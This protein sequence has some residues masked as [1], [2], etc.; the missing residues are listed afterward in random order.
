MNLVN[1]YW[2]SSC[3]GLLKDKIVSTHNKLPPDIVSQQ[4]SSSR[5]EHKIALVELGYNL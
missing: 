4:A 5:I 2:S 1:I 3:E